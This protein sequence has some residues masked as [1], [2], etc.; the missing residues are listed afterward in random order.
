MRTSKYAK[1]GKSGAEDKFLKAFQ[2][3]EKSTFVMA[4]SY[5]K[6]NVLLDG[7]VEA[8]REGHPENIQAMFAKLDQDWGKHS[9]MYRSAL[10]LI[11]LSEGRDDKSAIIDRALAKV[12]EQGKKRI[13]NH[14]LVN[15]MGNHKGGEV[16]YAALLKSGAS[17]DAALP[18]A[19]RD[20]YSSTYVDRLNLYKKAMSAGESTLRFWC[21]ATWRFWPWLSCFSS[22]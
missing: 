16:F 7:A 5:A 19:H 6:R 9:F 3:V 17:F 18:I 22:R 14:V 20:V 4:E 12:P 2:K 1:I 10:I 13:L 11:Q 8:F 15:A 21:L